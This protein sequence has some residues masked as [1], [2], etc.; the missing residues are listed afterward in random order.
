VLASG[1]SASY[2]LTSA[3]KPCPAISPTLVRSGSNWGAWA[4]PA[5][6]GARVMVVAGEQ[7]VVDVVDQR[8][9]V[10]V[11][12]HRLQCDR[13]GRAAGDRV[14]HR[15]AHVDGGGRFL[16]HGCYFWVA[17]STISMSPVLTS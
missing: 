10:V 12:V 2:S 17:G 14:R 15:G 3:E 8:G 6:N 9:D 1:V 7:G 16:A 4:V 5:A 11:V 13:V